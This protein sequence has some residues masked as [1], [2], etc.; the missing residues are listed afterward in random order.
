MGSKIML[1]TS[2]Q[3]DEL[4]T[5]LGDLSGLDREFLERCGP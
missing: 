5:A 2:R 3:V 4:L 1:I